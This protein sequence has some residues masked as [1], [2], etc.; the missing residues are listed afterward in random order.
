M[1]KCWHKSAL[2]EAISMDGWMGGAKHS[3]G[4]Y[5]GASSSMRGMGSHMG[6][7]SMGGMGGFMASMVAPIPPVGPSMG[8][9]YGAS[10]GHEMDAGHGETMGASMGGMDG[11]N[12][13]PM[14]GNGASTATTAA[15][16][17][18]NG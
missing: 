9:G 1:T 16:A 14:D 10:M 11:S 8:G 13:A 17:T 7:A 12:G 3:M 2:W 18:C 15:P 4:G 6:G 5:M